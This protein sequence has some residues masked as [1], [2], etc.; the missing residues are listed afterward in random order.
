MERARGS[1]HETDAEG[2][3]GLSRRF[4]V[5]GLIAAGGVVSTGLLVYILDRVGPAGS[6]DL[7]WILGYGVTVL[8]LWYLLIRPI[9]FS[10]R[11]TE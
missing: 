3:S 1:E 4:V 7:V 2:S 5:G 11:Y 8:A 6:A 9:D 10:T